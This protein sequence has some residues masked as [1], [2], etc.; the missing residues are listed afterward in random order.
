M[1]KRINRVNLRPLP[2]QRPACNL[3]LAWHLRTKILRDFPLLPIW[4]LSWFVVP[5][6][7]KRYGLFWTSLTS[8]NREFWCAQEEN[9]Y[10]TRPQWIPWALNFNKLISSNISYLLL[11]LDGP[12]Y[13]LSPNRMWMDQSVFYMKAPGCRGSSIWL[14]DL[15]D[16]REINGRRLDLWIT[17]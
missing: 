2:L 15:G 6:L 1:Q 8:G 11:H 16:I 12:W 7:C 9:A 10:M 3:A 14:Q 17:A 5:K 4:N 13:H